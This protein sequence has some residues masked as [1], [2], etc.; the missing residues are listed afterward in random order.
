MA[1][2]RISVSRAGTSHAMK[3]DGAHCRAPLPV[4]KRLTMVPSADSRAPAFLTCW[5]DVAKW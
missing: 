5:W 1:M 3:G 2:R 4:R